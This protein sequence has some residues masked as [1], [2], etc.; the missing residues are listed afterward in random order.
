[1][2]EE[3]SFI[4][5]LLHKL[6]KI[7]NNSPE[8]D[9]LVAVVDKLPYP[10]QCLS[11][12]PHG[13]FKRAGFEGISVC[14]LNSE[15]AAPDLWSPREWPSERETMTIQQRCS[16]SF[17]F[18]PN[19]I[20]SVMSRGLKHPRRLV[21]RELELPVANT[22]FQNGQTSTLFAERWKFTKSPE[23]EPEILRIRKVLLP[24]QSIQMTGI[25]AATDLQSQFGL[26][27]KLTSTT[28]S[29]I[30]AD[31]MGNIIR[32]LQQGPGEIVPASKE[33]ED[34]VSRLIE[35]GEGVK[36]I[37][38]WALV[39]PRESRITQPQSLPLDLHSRI[40]RGSRLHR[41]LSGGGGW[42]IKAGLL[43][44]EPDSTYSRL[45]VKELSNFGE[46][47]DVAMEKFQ[48]LGE[49][50]KPGDLIE[51]F[52]FLDNE[53]YKL[54]PKITGKPG[55]WLIATDPSVSFGTVPSRMDDPSST[56]EH[57]GQSR[58]PFQ[59]IFIKNHF[60]MLSEHGM[61]FKVDTYSPDCLTSH[62]ITEPLGPVVQTKL[63]P[64]YTMFT[65]K[66]GLRTSIT[67][68]LDKKNSAKEVS[69]K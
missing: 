2:D 55:S 42:G 12:E 62:A 14:V 54:P 27:I 35:T 51:F 36:K 32:K 15:A 56:D 68:V 4:G 67:R 37:D 61:S 53:Y 11:N 24:Q 34:V 59:Y 49:V 43:A 13:F 57:S 3:S 26:D 39:T 29:S 8:I 38:V 5:R 65:M 31:A 52:R 48:A 22:L 7:T 45:E 60:G 66:T 1:M 63:D 25:Y 40:E 17:K 47:Q 10:T 33:L 19:A 58:L 28:R 16:L 50:V 44:L 30:V 20:A 41:V 9:V 64:P 6:F 18:Q 69:V 21:S 46:G 23:S